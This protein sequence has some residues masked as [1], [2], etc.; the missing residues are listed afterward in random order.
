VLSATLAAVTTTVVTSLLSRSTPLCAF[1]PKY[2]WL[3]FLVWCISGSRCFSWFLVEDG[4]AI[5]V[6]ST[7]VPVRKS[8][9]ACGQVGVDGGEAAFAEIVGF[10]QPPEF[11]ERG[12]VRHALG[13]QINAGKPLHRLTV[14]KGVFAGC[15]GQAI[16]RLEKINPRHAAPTRWAGVRVRPWDRT[17]Q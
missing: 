11:Q 3:P 15:G 14:V 6:A 16:P 9:P 13:G 17:V 7:S 4:A 8:G 2:H 12:G 5:G 10:A 1:I